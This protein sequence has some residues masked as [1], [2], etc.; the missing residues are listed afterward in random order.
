MGAVVP[1]CETENRAGCTRFGLGC[2]NPG[3]QYFDGVC[4]WWCVVFKAGAS[5]LEGAGGLGAYLPVKPKTGPRG[6][7][8]D[9]GCKAR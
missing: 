1:S 3:A 7:G 9:L 6:C 5:E 4:G 8:F 2:G